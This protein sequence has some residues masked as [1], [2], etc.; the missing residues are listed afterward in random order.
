MQPDADS[1][2]ATA[3]PRAFIYDRNSRDRTGQ[4]TSVRDQNTDNQ[5]LCDRNGWTIAGIFQ[6][7]GKSA[8]R[9]AT[10]PRDGYDAMIRGIRNGLCDVLVVWESSRAYRTTR[11][12]IDLRDLCETAGVLLCINGRVNDMRRA[13]DR[14]STHIEALI[15]ER[16]AD[17]IRERVLRTTRLNAERGGPHG[18]VAYGYRRE[19]DPHTGALLRQVADEEQ[20][21]VVREIARAVADGRSLYSIA[22][23]LN[24]RGVPGPGGGVWRGPAL[25]QLLLKPTYLGQRVYRGVVMGDAAWPAILDEVT[26]YACRRV[27]DD[28]ARRTQRDTRVK[29]LLTGLARCFCGSALRV[30]DRSGDRVTVYWC[31]AG[32]CSTIRVEVL[33]QIVQ[34]ALLEYVERPQ[35]ARSLI[36]D[37]GGSGAMREALGRVEELEGRLAQARLQA[38]RL[39]LSTASLALLE[40]EWV[41]Q[42]ERA[43][44]A[45]QAAVV[46]PVLLRIAGPDARKVWRKMEGDVVQRRSVVREMVA[47][48]LNRAYA[49]GARRVTEDRYTLR[50]LR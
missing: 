16:E 21:A 49:R 3:P 9:Y 7:P 28:P 34:E 25:K 32:R 30:R 13:D 48:T 38:A 47:V 45:A 6:D 41:P 46:P 18:P 10:K 29:Y 44:A 26:Y 2:A 50:W 4:G 11:A 35:F 19:Y 42:I 27:L 1:A 24:G 37:S 12:Y 17:A 40:R 20:A 23:D 22:Q 31:P 8:S 5:R 33:D 15:A 36:P 43:R 39:E 14:F